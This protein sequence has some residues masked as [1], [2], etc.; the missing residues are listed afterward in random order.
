MRSLLDA[1]RGDNLEALYVLASPL[2]CDRESCWGSSGRKLTSTLGPCA[3]AEAST[4]APSVRPRPARDAVPSGYPR[5]AVAALRKHRRHG[6]GDAY[7]YGFSPTPKAVPIGHQNLHNRSWKPLS[8]VPVSPTPRGFTTYAIAAYPLPLAKG[9]GIVKSCGSASPGHAAAF[10]SS[11]PSTSSPS[12]NSAPA[13][14][15]ATR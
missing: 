2:A 11:L 8:S 15:S 13:L 7:P 12:L 1:A 14:T 3:S 9:G 5:L 6:R 4:R 10:F